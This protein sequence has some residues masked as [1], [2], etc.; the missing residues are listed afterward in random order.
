MSHRVSGRHRRPINDTAT[1]RST[2]A[3]YS[4][5]GTLGFLVVGIVTT[6]PFGTFT[7]ASM[8]ATGTPVNDTNTVDWVVIDTDN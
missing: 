4:G 2:S 6:G 3:H 8:D 5:S 7:I 1:V